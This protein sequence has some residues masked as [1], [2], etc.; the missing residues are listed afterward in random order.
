MPISLPAPASATRCPF[1]GRAPR[2]LHYSNRVGRYQDRP[3]RPKACVY[4]LRRE[5]LLPPFWPLP[6]PRPLPRVVLRPS[7]R[8][9]PRVG[10]LRD[11]DLGRDRLLLLLLLLLDFDL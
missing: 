9:R 10:F 11:R 2:L 5:N 8:P 1:P 7:P 4:L 6:R 3:A